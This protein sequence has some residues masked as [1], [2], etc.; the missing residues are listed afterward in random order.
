MTM[1]PVADRLRLVLVLGPVVLLLAVAVAVPRWAMCFGGGALAWALVAWLLGRGRAQ[2]G[3]RT[4]VRHLRHDNMAQAI[5]AMDAL[6]RAEPEQAEH[7]RFRAELH[8]LAGDLRAAERDYQQVLARAPGSPDGHLGLAEVAV[9]RGDYRRAQE[10]AAQASLCAPD[11]WRVSYTRA[12]IADRLGDSS[13]ALEYAR[14]ALSTG[15]TDRRLV[16]LVHLWRARNWARLGDR[17]AARAA[18]Q[19]MRK[20]ASGLRDWRRLLANPQAASLQ[21]MVADDLRQ[22]E[23]LL[24]EQTAQALLARW[25]GGAG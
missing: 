13:A 1:R 18:L 21:T 20:A 3:Y 15:L 17:D 6:I 5:A 16:M 10:H 11:D 22:I 8:R 19:D 24:D 23:A 14:A 9:Q 25:S 12:L 2:M 4:V 7:Y